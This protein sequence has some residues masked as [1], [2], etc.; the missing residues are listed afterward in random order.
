MPR[1][2]AKE[3]A[4]RPLADE[5]GVDRSNLAETSSGKRSAKRLPPA[6][7]GRRRVAGVGVGFGAYRLTDMLACRSVGRTIGN[8]ALFTT[9]LTH[10]SFPLLK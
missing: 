8:G 4:L 6:P 5:L 7:A 1:A 10:R 9:S 2:R 3:M